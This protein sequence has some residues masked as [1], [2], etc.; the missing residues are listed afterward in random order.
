MTCRSMT[1]VAVVC[2]CWQDPTTPFLIREKF[3]CE[4]NYQT[5]GTTRLGVYIL[6][7]DIFYLNAS[8]VATIATFPYSVG[9]TG[10]EAYTVSGTSSMESLV[11]NFT[12][13]NFICSEDMGQP[14]SDTFNS[15]E[16]VMQ[17][18]IGLLFRETTIGPYFPECKVTSLRAM[19]NGFATRVDFLCTHRVVPVKPVVDSEVYWEMSRETHGITILCL[20]TLA[21]DSHYLDGYKEE[22]MVQSTEVLWSPLMLPPWATGKKT[23]SI[24]PRAVALEGEGHSA[25]SNW[26]PICARPLTECA[27]HQMPFVRVNWN[28]SFSS[29]LGSNSIGQGFLDGTRKTTGHCPRGLFKLDNLHMT[30]RENRI[31]SGWGNCS[32]KRRWEGALRQKESLGGLESS[33][34]G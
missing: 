4:L 10:P 15:A 28:C 23:S 29:N 32:G 31:E 34:W 27:L 21:K 5:Y 19:M 17:H 11:A 14:S 24:H 33:N 30:S 26:V 2:H 3:S 8:G 12:V 13:T 20:F 7:N 18:M 16:N 22:S 9:S 1:R 6:K 25:M